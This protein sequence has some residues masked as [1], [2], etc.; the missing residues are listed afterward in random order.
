M[1]SSITEL[2]ILFAELI[3]P[4]LVE[5]VHLPDPRITY[6]VIVEEVKQRHP[7]LKAVKT[8]H[9]RHVG[10]R[11]GTI[12]AFTHDQGCPHIGALV[13]DA[14]NGECGVG[15]Y[16]LTDSDPEL[17]RKRIKGYP[18]WKS[19]TLNFEQHI[20]IVK[21]KK[22][23]QE[24]KPKK[25]SW[26]EA[27]DK[28]AYYW[29][30]IKANSPIDKK[31]I[32][33]QNNKLREIVRQGFCPAIAFAQII[34]ELIESGEYSEEK[35]AYLYVGEYQ[36]KI[37]SDTAI[38]NLVKIGFSGNLENRS[39]QLA[40]NLNLTPLKF[41]MLKSWKFKPGYAYQAEQQIH[42]ILDHLRHEG[43]FFNSQDGFVPEYVEELVKNYLSDKLQTE[44]EVNTQTS[45]T[46]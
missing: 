39:K 36:N 13:V 17:E 34:G 21:M 7:H 43:E 25:I 4:I 23:D 42:G 40:G 11:L 5:R 15:I 12:W 3:F 37:D 29:R 10:R 14:E 6:G 8:F 9:H 38:F 31:V 24:I 41:K 27:K 16:G 19:V 30:D 22:R 28:T 2:D 18:D 45:L 33:K 1:S 35:S 46:Y 44:E 26:D 20:A 32:E